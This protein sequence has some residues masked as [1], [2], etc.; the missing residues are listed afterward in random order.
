V[1]HRACG[2]VVVATDSD[3]HAALQSLEGRARANGVPVERNKLAEPVG[4]SAGEPDS[5]SDI[6]DYIEHLPNGPTHFIRK[7]GD[8]MPLDNTEVFVV[9]PRHYFFMGDNRDNSRDS[10]DPS[11]GVGYVPEENLVGKAEFLFFSLQ[12]GAH[13]WEIW[14]WPTSVRWHRLLMKIG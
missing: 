5:R 4:V 6:T 1:P 3:Q 11:G 12:N 2:K 7:E 13:F 10:R 8:D 9:P 14:K